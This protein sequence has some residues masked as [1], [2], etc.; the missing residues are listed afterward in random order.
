M[1][2]YLENIEMSKQIILYTS[3]LSNNASEE[4][5]KDAEKIIDLH[6]YLI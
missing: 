4:W 6:V 5:E 3:L 2:K 1:D